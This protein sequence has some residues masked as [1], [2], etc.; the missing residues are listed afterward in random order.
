MF[1]IALARVRDFLNQVLP[2][3]EEGFTVRMYRALTKEYIMKIERSDARE[4]YPGYKT[5]RRGIG[6]HGRASRKCGEAV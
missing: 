4:G 1:G 2:R 5:A 3:E 6:S